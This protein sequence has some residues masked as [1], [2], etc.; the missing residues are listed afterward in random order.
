MSSVIEKYKRQAAERAVEF[1]QSNKLVGLGGGTTAI[2]AVRHIA[3]LL[4]NGRLQKILGVP[5]SLRVE[6][7]AR[8][9]GIP[10]TTLE[11]HPIIDLTID[12]ADEVDDN[13]NLIKGRGGAHLR[14]KIIAQASLREIIVVDDSKLSQMLG[15]LA[16]VP[17]EVLPFG[18]S[19]QASYLESIGAQV[20]LR[21]NEDGSIFLTDQNNYIL[22]CN[23]GPI[24]HLEKLAEQLRSRAGIIEHGL[25]LGL[26]TDLIV[27]GK[28][29]TRHIQKI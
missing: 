25:F 20:K 7:E 1:V 14:E 9:L 4:Q 21:K 26:S 3:N 2:Y 24:T 16:P 23:F 15:T 19:L 10:L 13:L 12:G 6:A 17:V 8:R 11:E 5:C 22:D 27:A 29:G 28:A 18:F